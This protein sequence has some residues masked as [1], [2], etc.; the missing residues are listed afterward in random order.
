MA[1]K[2]TVQHID[3]Y[4]VFILLVGLDLLGGVIVSAILWP[5]NPFTHCLFVSR[6]AVSFNT[7]CEN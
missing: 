5:F 1:F 2:R 4:I 7:V 3:F 6:A